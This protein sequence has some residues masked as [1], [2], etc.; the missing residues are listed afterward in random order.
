MKH[1]LP[2]SKKHRKPMKGGKPKKK[3]SKKSY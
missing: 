3:P 2:P 1:G